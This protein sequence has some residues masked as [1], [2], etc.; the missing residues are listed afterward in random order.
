[1]A[2]RYNFYRSCDSR[3]RDCWDHLFGRVSENLRF[4]VPLSAGDTGFASNWDEA[5]P[6]R[7]RYG[8]EGFFY[9]SLVSVGIN[10]QGDGAPILLAHLRRLGP[11]SLFQEV[12]IGQSVRDLRLLRSRIFL[13]SRFLPTD[14]PLETNNSFD[15]RGR[16]RRKITESLV[17]QWYNLGEWR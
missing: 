9:R 5:S 11:P 14:L 10:R 8:I 12:R 4:K 13:H 2:H 7:A 6:R 17:A 15:L 3:F 16:S 1:L